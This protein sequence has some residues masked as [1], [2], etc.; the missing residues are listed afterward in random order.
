MTRRDSIPR[1]LPPEA[2]ALSVR[3]RHLTWATIKAAIAG[4]GDGPPMSDLFHSLQVRFLLPPSSVSTVLGFADVVLCS[5]CTVGGM[6]WL[7]SIRVC[8]RRD[9]SMADLLLLQLARSA[10]VYVAS[11]G[12]D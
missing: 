5:A 11:P 9:L 1:P 8:L 6:S 12:S 3:L 10:P 7:P 4:G 2:S